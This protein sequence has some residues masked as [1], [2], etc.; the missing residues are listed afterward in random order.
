MGE[1]RALGEQ[2][3]AHEA[4]GERPRAVVERARHL[5]CGEGVLDVAVGRAEENTLRAQ[6]QLVL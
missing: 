6:L 5:S 3:L 1:E 2:L 4:R